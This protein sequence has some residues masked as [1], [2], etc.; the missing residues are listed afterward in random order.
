VQAEKFVY[1]SRDD[2]S[3]GASVGMQIDSFKCRSPVAPKSE[4]ECL[5]KIPLQSP[6]HDINECWGP[7]VQAYSKRYLAWS[8]LGVA[9]IVY[10]FVVVPLSVFHP[11][12]NLLFRSIHCL[13]SIFWTLDFGLVAAGHVS[14]K[15][16]RR[17]SEPVDS[18]V[19]CWLAFDGLL[20]L[21]DW[22][23][24]G[25]CEGDLSLSWS[26]FSL[27]FLRLLRAHRLP[28]LL[29]RLVQR[30]NSYVG[31]LALSILRLA[32]CICFA[33]HYVACAW[34]GIF[35]SS[36]SGGAIAESSEHLAARYAWSL[37]WAPLASI[38]AED[39][40]SIQTEQQYIFAIATALAA[41]AA[42]VGLFGSITFAVIQYLLFDICRHQD[43]FSDWSLQDHAISPDVSARLRSY[44]QGAAPKLTILE[45]EAPS[46]MVRS[47]RFRSSV[48]EE[49]EL[50]ARESVLCGHRFFA[51]LNLN[52]SEV[53]RQ[54]SHMALAEEPIS[55]G[56]VLF[57]SGQPGYRMRFVAS[58][59][60]RY[61]LRTPLADPPLNSERV[62]EGQWLS[63]AALWMLWEHRGDFFAASDGLVLA[64]LADCFA[65]VM[66]QHKM[67]HSDAAKYAAKF[68]EVMKY[69][70]ECCDLLT[71]GTMHDALFDE[72]HGVHGEAKPEIC[73]L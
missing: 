2:Q 62:Y 12:D 5:P 16:H 24:F 7:A 21:N 61:A 60:L 32:L 56:T 35:R 11:E 47:H 9:F 53:L 72:C 26:C 8:I 33:N 6:P 43:W 39:L 20:V 34:Y 52:Y 31:L 40:R 59:S 65:S 4:W 17:I 38:H 44:F 70:G 69:T 10:D 36:I 48:I 37:C 46:L 58:G 45:D 13:A 51:R 25:F 15:L 28:K 1:C 68:I 41:P 73:S 66:R 3:S 30:M 42:L 50:K 57:T 49:A 71:L 29:H 64:L 23:T 55:P 27:R 22:L 18:Y 14:D 67:V 54:L 63:E 19:L